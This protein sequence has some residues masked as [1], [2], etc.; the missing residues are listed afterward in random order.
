MELIFILKKNNMY[1]FVLILVSF[2]FFAKGQSHIITK[3]NI[4][5]IRVGLTIIL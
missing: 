3:E 1:K 5:I 4:G 2:S